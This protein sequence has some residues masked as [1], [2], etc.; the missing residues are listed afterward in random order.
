M[1]DEEAKQEKR[2]NTFLAYT[3]EAK[4]NWFTAHMLESFK[5]LSV[6]FAP[7]Y[8]YPKADLIQQPVTR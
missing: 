7:N 6:P 4:P 8:T 1:K 5:D 3:A 2:V